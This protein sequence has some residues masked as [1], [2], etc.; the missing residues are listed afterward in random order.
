MLNETGAARVCADCEEEFGPQKVEP[1]QDKTHSYCK[2][3]MIAVCNYHGKSELAAQYAQ[4]PDERFPPDLAL[5]P[6]L[7][8]HAGA[9]EWRAQRDAFRAYQAR[10]AG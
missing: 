5:H 6:E 2:R 3:H 8:D 9:T 10:Q 4:E 7:I 1:G